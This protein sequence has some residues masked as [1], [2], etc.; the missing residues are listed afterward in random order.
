MKKINYLLP[1]IWMALSFSV[2]TKG[3]TIPKPSFGLPINSRTI[4]TNIRFLLDF[5]VPTLLLADN[6]FPKAKR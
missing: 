5:V 4:V 1:P 2:F 6:L 3:F